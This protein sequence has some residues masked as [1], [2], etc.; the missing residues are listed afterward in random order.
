MQK[1]QTSQLPELSAEQAA[2]TVA[3]AADS[4]KGT[5]I[6]ALHVTELTSIADYFVLITGGSTTHV[7]AL[8]EAVDEAMS[9]AG[10]EPLHVEGRGEANWILMD[11][12]DVVVHIFLDEARGFYGLERLWGDAPKL[13]LELL[14]G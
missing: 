4:K 1:P 8:F 5:D 11:Y 3:S 13:D 6:V 14:P 2:R 10:R 9:H 7:N 12:G